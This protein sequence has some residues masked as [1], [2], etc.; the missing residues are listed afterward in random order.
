M[1]ILFNGTSDWAYGALPSPLSTNGTG[2]SAYALFRTGATFVS[3]TILS[4][5]ITAAG[6]VGTFHGFAIRVTAAGA[7]NVTINTS[8]GSWATSNVGVMLPNTTY[9]VVV[10]KAAGDGNFRIYFNKLNYTAIS[11]GATQN[12]SSITGILLSR[13]ASANSSYFNGEIEDV[14]VWNSQLSDADIDVLFNASK[15]PTDCSAQPFAYWP[16]VSSDVAVS[17]GTSAL[18][19]T[20]PAI[21]ASTLITSAMLAPTNRIIGISD[22]T[23]YTALN[24]QYGAAGELVQPGF[25][26]GGNGVVYRLGISTELYTTEAVRLTLRDASGT[27]LTTGVIGKTGPKGDMTC[28]VVPVNIVAG[29]TYFIG[30]S[31]KGDLYL[32]YSGKAGGYVNLRETGSTYNAPLASFVLS[33]RMN[34]NNTS[35]PPVW[36]EGQLTGSLESVN[37]GSTLVGPGTY[38]WTTA[39]FTPNQGNINGFPLTNVNATTFT[40]PDFIDGVAYPAYGSCTI[41]A[42]DG[43]NSDS[44]VVSYQMPI[45]MQSVLISDNEANT[46]LFIQ[47]YTSL[48][49]GDIV[50]SKIPSVLGVAVN[51]VDTDGGIY[52]DYLGHQVI[53]KRNASNVMTQINL[54]TALLIDL[55]SLIKNAT[56]PYIDGQ[57]PLGNR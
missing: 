24:F 15:K 10:T 17:A 6:A 19:R 25:T 12:T 43:T 9:R 4:T 7:I 52:T 57:Y 47:K 54:N 33:G 13:S 21:A 41:T 35:V 39:N 20:G 42:S 36:A 56:K 38:L 2:V 1:S 28:D 49:I 14:T 16:L 45:D 23:A 34:G 18:V 44:L 29:Q 26:A 50:Y 27:L 37:G 53:W 3:S 40:I 51:Y 22:Y 8:G 31:T 5:S 32:Q 46:D 48:A 30:I 11:T 55:T